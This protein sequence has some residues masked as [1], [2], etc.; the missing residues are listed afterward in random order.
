[1]NKYSV[2]E[3]EFMVKDYC[4]DFDFIIYK[5]VFNLFSKVLNCDVLN[6]MNKGKSKMVHDVIGKI[7]GKEIS[8]ITNLNQTKKILERSIKNIEKKTGKLNIEDKHYI[9]E[10]LICQLEEKVA[11]S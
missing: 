8:R 3:I 7:D 1:M 9:V 10:T 2:E 5:D 4:K 6:I 11:H